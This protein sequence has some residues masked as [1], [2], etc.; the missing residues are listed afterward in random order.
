MNNEKQERR[1]SKTRLAKIRNWAITLIIIGGI[2]YLLSLSVGS[3]P[4]DVDTSLTTPSAQDQVKGTFA[5]GKPVLIEYSDFQCPACGAFYPSVEEMLAEFGDDIVF[6][7]RHFPLG[8]HIHAPITAI[9]AEAAGRQGAFWDMYNLIFQNQATWSNLTGPDVRASL[10]SYAE[11]IGLDMT[12]FE[13]DL[14]DDVLA[15]K[16][17]GDYRGGIRNKVNST[18]TFFLNGER[19]NMSAFTDLRDNVANAVALSAGIS[20]T[21]P[22]EIPEEM[23]PDAPHGTGTM[24][25]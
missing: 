4:S 20:E 23:T 22:L 21:I 8:Q 11:E 16:V 17:S 7:Y 10:L 12:Q 19:L 9:A 15:N 24:Q 3:S 18:P 14:D 13:A 5:E 25:Q 6:V 1:E 2:I